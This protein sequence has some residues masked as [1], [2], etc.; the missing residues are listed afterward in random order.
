MLEK[1]VERRLVAQLKKLGIKNI[2][3]SAIGRRGLPDR[4]IFL[5]GGQA[6][7]IELKSPDRKNNL[8]V[9]QA[10]E[11][12]ELRQLGFPVLVSSDAM[13]CVAWI[14]GFVKSAE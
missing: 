6:L 8:S 1:D 13:E 14:Q 4:Q 5:P 3:L 11:I 9:G 12:E 10:H 7:F 2:K